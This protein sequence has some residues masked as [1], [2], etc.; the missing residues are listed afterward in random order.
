MENSLVVYGTFIRRATKLNIDKIEMVQRRS[1]RFV[2]NCYDHTASVTNKLN[3]LEWDPL[4]LR[5][6][7]NR[8]AMM[9]MLIHIGLAEV[10]KYKYLIPE[11]HVRT[12]RHLHNLAYKVV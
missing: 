8:L 3:N 1:V 12:S 2:T 9:Y 11:S 10:N 7:R 6:K 5:E 4:E